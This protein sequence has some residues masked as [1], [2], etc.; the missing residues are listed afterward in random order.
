MLS[1]FLWA[2]HSLSSIRLWEL[3]LSFRPVTGPVSPLPSLHFFQ[4][5]T[6]M[7]QSCECGMASLPQLMPCLP[8]EGELF[9]FPLLTVKAFPLRSPS[10]STEGL[11]P[12]MSLLH[13]GESL[14]TPIFQGFLFPFFLLA[15]R[16]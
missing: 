15:F 1:P 7:G 6:I 5:G 12:P 9:K 4:T 11:T 2:L 3:L 14:Q 13:S 8:V 16:A 10:L